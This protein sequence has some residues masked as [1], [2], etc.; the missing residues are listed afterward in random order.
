MEQQV[1]RGDVYTRVTNRIVADLEAGVRPWCQRWDSHEPAPMALP[2]RHNGTPY[3]GMNIVLLWAQ[4]MERGFASSMWMTYKQAQALGG[5]V[6]KGETGSLVVY[7]DRYTKT[8]TDANGD[9]LAREIAFMKGYTVF[10][11]GQI[12]NLPELYRPKPTPKPE[13]GRLHVLNQAAETFIANTGA[14]IEH[15]GDRAFYAIARDLIRLPPMSSFVDAEAYTA[16]KAHELIHWT[17]HPSRLNRDF[18]AKRFG[19]HGYATE[20]LVAE[21]GAAFL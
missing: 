2:L 19:D 7:A 21:L 12:D 8:E 14:V 1:T 5:Q 10:N 15:E 20:E 11:V 17:R 16:T 18:G 13:A 4:A 9:E 3:R 6:R